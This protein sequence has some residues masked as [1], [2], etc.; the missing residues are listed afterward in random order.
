MK[1]SWTNHGVGTLTF[2]Y[3]R[4]RLSLDIGLAMTENTSYLELVA[5]TQRLS[6]S[7]GGHL[8]KNQDT[9][10][11]FLSQAVSAGTVNSTISSPVDC[12]ACFWQAVRQDHQISNGRELRKLPDRLF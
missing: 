4:Q 9:R 2:Q 6:L 1:H 5:V 11:D 8:A 7:K 3:T 10:F 12:E